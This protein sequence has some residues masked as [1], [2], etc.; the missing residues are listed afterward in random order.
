MEDA[1]HDSSSGSLVP[2]IA[3]DAKAETR[4]VGPC[5]RL[6]LNPILRGGVPPRPIRAIH[7]PMRQSPCGLLI[8]YL[9]LNI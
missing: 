5:T 2:L 9:E 6:G 4:S 1:A 7:V 3:S 8:F